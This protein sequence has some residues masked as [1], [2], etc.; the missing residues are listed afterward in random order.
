M[1]LRWGLLS[2][3]RIN[4]ALMEGARGTDAA[5]IVAVA[6]RD[7]G[8][9]E[10]Y[11]GG[12]GIARFYG[13]YDALLADP[14]IDAVYNPLPNGMHVEWSVRALEAGK[15]VLCEKPL[16][17]R[18]ADAS[19]AF[20]AADAAGRVLAEAFMWRHLP[21][22]R[23]LRELLDEGAIGRLRAI[24]SSFSFPLARPGDIR[25]KA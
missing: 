10:A 8:R 5:E 15:H 11:A 20:D 9:A 3:A 21:Q 19:A 23:R 12:H 16:S 7:A 6:S 1:G 2:T 4:D 18:A 14:E 24:R 25:F 17:R 22:T 13:S